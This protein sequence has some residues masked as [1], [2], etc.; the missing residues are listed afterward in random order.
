MI[1][2]T[3]VSSTVS[4][5]A[6]VLLLA[7]SAF[8]VELDSATAMTTATTIVALVGSLLAIFSRKRNREVPAAKATIYSADLKAETEIR[9]DVNPFKLKF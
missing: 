6:M 9:A 7:A 5:I 4:A 2:F 1:D 3:Q 8:N